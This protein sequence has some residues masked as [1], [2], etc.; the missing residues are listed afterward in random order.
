M[1]CHHNFAMAHFIPQCG[2]IT[3]HA[4]DIFHGRKYHI[5]FNVV[6]QH[7]ACNVHI[8]WQKISHLFNVVSQHTACN[9]HFSLQKKTT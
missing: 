1:I 7:T 4:V 2:I 3:W 5:L 8:S 6:A 9:V